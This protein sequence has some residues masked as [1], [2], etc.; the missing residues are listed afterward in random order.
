MKVAEMQETMKRLYEELNDTY[1]FV[2]IRFENRDYAVGDEC[3][4]SKDNSGREDEREFPEFGTEEYDELPLLDGTCVYDL[5]DYDY[6][7]DG[8]TLNKDVTNHCFADHAYIVAG[9]RKGN[10]DA[11]APDNG[12]TLIQDAVVVHKIF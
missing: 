4:W 6:C 10:M 11:Y 1:S 3:E 2:G 5:G 8:Y 7:L 9:T 12:E